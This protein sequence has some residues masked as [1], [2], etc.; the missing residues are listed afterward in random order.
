MTITHRDGA[1]LVEQYG[2]NIASGF[3]RF[4]TLRNDIGLQRA[5]HPGNTDSCEQSADSSRNQADEQR[6]KGW[7]VSAEA[8]QRLGNTQ[9][10]AH[11][12]F[13]IPGHRP[14]RNNYYQ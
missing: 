11:I 4:A 14:Q 6:D 9:I 12:L 5:I 10:A 7:N 8:A 13:G 1:S 3:D 2:I